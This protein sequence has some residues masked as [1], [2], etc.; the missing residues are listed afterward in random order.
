MLRFF[1]WLLLVAC[2]NDYPMVVPPADE[3]GV[4]Y[5]N[6][7]VIY[8]AALFRASSS[9]KV[10]MYI[11]DC[12]FSFGG[13]GGPALL[14]LLAGFCAPCFLEKKKSCVLRALSNSL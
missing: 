8:Y 5:Y 6:G 7:L 1:Y 11:V 14:F 12:D 4:N 2:E 13:K 10:N 3:V 9:L